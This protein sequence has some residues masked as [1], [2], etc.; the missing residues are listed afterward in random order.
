MSTLFGVLSSRPKATRHPAASNSPQV[1]AVALADD[2]KE[3]KTL[4]TAGFARQD[5]QINDLKQ[6]LIPDLGMPQDL[7]VLVPDLGVPPDLYSS[8][9]NAPNPKK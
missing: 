1:A 3:L 9:P 2:L 4:A 7:G 5:A 8:T 6:S